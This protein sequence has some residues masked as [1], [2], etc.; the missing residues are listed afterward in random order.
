MAFNDFNLI[1]NFLQFDCKIVLQLLFY[2]YFSNNYIHTVILSVHLRNHYIMHNSNYIYS[3]ISCIIKNF[4]HNNFNKN[5]NY[6]SSNFNTYTINNTNISS[7]I[8][9]RDIN[10][11]NNKN[12][13]NNIN[14]SSNINF[15]RNNMNFRGNYFNNNKYI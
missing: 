1:V 4:T 5:I 3:M 13:S 2:K 8:N 6:N 15:N 7:N 10:N 9:N 12:N 14:I 11:I